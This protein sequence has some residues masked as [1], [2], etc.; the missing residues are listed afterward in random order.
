MKCI[1]VA[2]VN[3][4]NYRL[5]VDLSVPIKE[6]SWFIL[7]PSFKITKYMNNSSLPEDVKKKFQ[8]R[9]EQYYKGKIQFKA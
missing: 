6:R 4:E 2:S 3:N 7:M 9:L 5:Y 8:L 1:C